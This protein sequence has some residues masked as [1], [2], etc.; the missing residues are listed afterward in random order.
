[1][2]WSL[3]KRPRKLDDMFGQD[4]VK[5]YYKNIYA[6][7]SKE[8]AEEQAKSVA[9][10][11]YKMK[12][13]NE[14]PTVSVFMGRYGT[15]K[16]TAAQI[17]AMSM[18]CTNP[19]AEG[20]PCCECLSCSSVINQTFDN[21]IIQIDGGQASKDDV[22]DTITDFIKTGPFYA[23]RK[24]VIVEEV[25]ELSDKARNS[26]LRITETAKRNIHFIFTSMENLPASGFL[27]RSQM[28]K[29]RY[30]PV[31][32]VM[33]YLKSVMESEGLWENPQI[34]EEFKFQGLATIAANA[35]GSYR[36]AL[37]ILQ[38]CIVT[39]SYTAE[40]IKNNFGY[41][42]YE[43]FSNIMIAILNGSTDEAIFNSFIEGDYNNTYNLAY[44]V[45]SDAV[46][47]NTFKRV[48]GGKYFEKQAQLIS[49]H[50][51]F[52]IMLE[53]FKEL[54][55]ST[56]TG[57]LKKSDYIIAMCELLSKCKAAH[58]PAPMAPRQMPTRPLPTRG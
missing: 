34:P 5:K 17:V 10:P 20:N 4:H 6:I 29:F 54:S 31:E 36:Q 55:N 33:Y 45:V 22:I 1:M 39:E 2:Q 53:T 21:D 16:T 30:A 13:I 18:A 9:D 28:F 57:F 37:Q 27:S 46:Q 40:D 41:V 26:M 35:D 50:G 7:E 23:R 52:P 3:S 11:T 56:R 14:Y 19:D 24:V 48:S 8:R 58:A 25:Q 44:K 42:D 12:Y 47:W 51:N 43:S 15:G 38:Q 49:G 32:D